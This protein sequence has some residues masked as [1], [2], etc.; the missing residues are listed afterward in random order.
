MVML[1][2]AP[3]ST[4]F[5]AAAGAFF[6]GVL[7]DRGVELVTGDGLER[8]EGDGERVSRVVTASGAELPADMVV[9]GTGAMPDV[10][11]AR[12]A[13]LELGET[14]GVACSADLETSSRGVWAAG[15]MCEYDS[16]LHG[17]RARIE[18]FEVARAQGKAV[19]SAML[20]T[21][22]PFQEVPYF[23]TDLADWTGAEWVGLG[24]TPAERE[25][26]R[27]D[28]ARG[29][30]SVLHLAEGRVVGALSVG[31]EA[32]LAAARRLI[33]EKTD[34]A[35]RERDLADADLEAL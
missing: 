16:V 32:D 13:G 18:H 1:E 28:P 21:R 29:E 31:R 20:G 7:R 6:A 27:G 5:G 3:L 12:A 11:L 15:D 26:V 10:M 24:E 8:L 9:M 35:G 23:W 34:L 30:F 19:A 33:A 2:D 17:R 4:H 22:E 25:V 14:G